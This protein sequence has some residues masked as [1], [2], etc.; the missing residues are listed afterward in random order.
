MGI[1]DDLY[2]EGAKLGFAK[3]GQVKDTGN[4]PATKGDSQQEIEAGGRGKLRPGYKKG[5]KTEKAQYKA[6]KGAAKMAAK[7]VKKLNRMKTHNKK[8]LVGK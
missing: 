1:H 7:G 3:G 4:M 2:K 8:P 5:G 6:K